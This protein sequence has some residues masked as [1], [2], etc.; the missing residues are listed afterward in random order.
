MLGATSRLVEPSLH[1]AENAKPLLKLFDALTGS[2]PLLRG[3]HQLLHDYTSTLP[4]SGQW[5]GC[6][7]TH[8]AAAQHPGFLCKACKPAR[9]PSI[10][11]TGSLLPAALHPRNNPR[12]HCC[13]AKIEHNGSPTR[14]SAQ[15]KACRTL[16]KIFL[17]RFARIDDDATALFEAR[18]DQASHR[19][20]KDSPGQDANKIVAQRSSAML[21]E[22]RISME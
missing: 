13:R 7:H 5:T 14:D 15:T 20:L 3:P 11:L 21:I 4:R 6:R 17:F 8:S 22:R 9:S 12:Q 1:L 16:R 18:D 10:F 19:S 2:D